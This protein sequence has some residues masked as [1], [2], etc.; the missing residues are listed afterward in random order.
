MGDAALVLV[1]VLG[2]TRSSVRVEDVNIEGIAVL[3]PEQQEPAAIDQPAR[4]I[5]SMTWPLI[6]GNGAPPRRRSIGSSSGRPV[7]RP[8]APRGG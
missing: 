3:E 5:S 8:D 7:R 6:I 1:G 2:H 4:W